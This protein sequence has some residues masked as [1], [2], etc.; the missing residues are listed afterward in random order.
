MLCEQKRETHHVRHCAKV[1]KLQQVGERVLV[2]SVNEEAA[3]QARWILLAK[4]QWLFFWQKEATVS[5]P[6]R[7]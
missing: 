2:C 1:V 4:C 3:P 5:T 7:F 6:Q